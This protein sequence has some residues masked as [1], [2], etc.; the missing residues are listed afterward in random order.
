MI[1]GSGSRSSSPF[2]HTMFELPSNSGLCMSALIT[3]PVHLRLSFGSIRL[4]TSSTV[5][6]SDPH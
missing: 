3:A 1:S 6:Y 4:L 2:A 5:F